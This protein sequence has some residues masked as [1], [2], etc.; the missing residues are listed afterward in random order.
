MEALAAQGNV[1]EGLR[2]FDR[3][4]TLLRDELGTM[5]SP[6]TIAAHERLLRPGSRSASGGAGSEP[7]PT[8]SIELPA[9]LL[10]R[11]AAP[12]VGRERELEELERLWATGPRLR[13][14]AAPAL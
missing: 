13:A 9:E 6:E 3:L 1:A 12:M 11:S 7:Q 5:P 10:A 2:V 8:E 4:R 14:A